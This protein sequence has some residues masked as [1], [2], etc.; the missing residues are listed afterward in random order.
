[1]VNLKEINLKRVFNIEGIDDKPLMDELESISQEYPYFHLARICHLRALKSK[2]KNKA[3]SALLGQV[4]SIS[5]DRTELK[6][7]LFQPLSNQEINDYGLEAQKVISARKK[8]L[9]NQNIAQAKLVDTFIQTDEGAKTIRPSAT[10][11]KEEKIDLVK[12][13]LSKSKQISTETLAQLYLKQKKYTKAKEIF[14]LLRVTNSEKSDYF[15]SQ[16]KRVETLQKKN[17]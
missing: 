6:N 13:S 14:E 16:I 2:N 8:A 1:M 5:Y 15:A 12:S 3:Y 7:F 11:G 4:A 10:A 9:K 17:K